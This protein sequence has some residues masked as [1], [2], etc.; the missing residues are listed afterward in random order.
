[1]EIDEVFWEKDVEQSLKN[2]RQTLEH[3]KQTI[4]DLRKRLREYNKDAEIVKRDQR[5]RDLYDHSAAGTENTRGGAA[6]GYT[7]LPVPESGC[8][9]KSNAQ[10]AANRRISQISIHGKRKRAAL[11][12]LEA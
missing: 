5:I 6:N 11:K 8:A 3:Q 7:P 1:M 10:S 12:R 9:L 4:E 2:I